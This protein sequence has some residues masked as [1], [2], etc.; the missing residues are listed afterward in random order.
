MAKVESTTNPP[1][2]YCVLLNR[3]KYANNLMMYYR[4]AR[5]VML[6]HFL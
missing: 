2:T 3:I 4:Q 5:I 1:V 6:Y